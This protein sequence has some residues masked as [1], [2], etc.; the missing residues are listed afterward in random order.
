MI[1][2]ISGSASQIASSIF[3]KIDTSNK[4]YIEQSDLQTA[5]NNIDSSDNGAN[6][7]ELF[8]SL[9]SDSD[10]KLT[11]SELS[12]GVSNLLSQLNSQFDSSRVQGGMP[13]PSP[14]Q[15]DEEDEGYT[16]DELE[17]IASST[18]DSK[19]SSLMSNV[20]ANFEAADTNEDGKVSAKEAMAY[21][22]AQQQQGNSNQSQ[23]T[24]GQRENNIDFQ[25]S[26]LITAYSNSE[27]NSSSLS[28]AA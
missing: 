28:L 4:G 17:S 25:I 10:G 16:Q 26:Q 3:S 22:Q 15:G 13:P 11:E 24:Q 12:D 1:S 19:L 8:S 20:A 9:D 14:P 5:F 7:N 23:A 21:E 27:Q 18:S 6:I 2:S